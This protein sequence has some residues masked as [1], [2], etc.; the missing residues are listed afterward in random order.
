[1]RYAVKVTGA[2][3]EEF[4]NIS[5]I[6]SEFTVTKLTPPETKSPPFEIPQSPNLSDYKDKIIE[7][8]KQCLYS[9]KFCFSNISRCIE[10]ISKTKDSVL[11]RKLVVDTVKEFANSIP[12][13]MAKFSTSG[14]IYSFWS[15]CMERIHR[16]RVYC[17]SATSSKNEMN[18]RDTFLHH[19]KDAY[20]TNNTDMFK[21]VVNVIVGEYINT[22]LSDEFVENLK[23][24]FNFMK[25][26][27]LFED[28]FIHNFIESICK[29]I[30]ERVESNKLMDLSVYLKDLSKKIYNLEETKARSLLQPDSEDSKVLREVKIAIK[31]CLIELR[32]SQNTRDDLKSLA[33]QND[34]DAIN[35][36]A[37][38]CSETS[39]FNN[40][41]SELTNVFRDLVADSFNDS[42]PISIIISYYKLLCGLSFVDPGFSSTLCKKLL[43]GFEKGFNR[44]IVRDTDKDI[45]KD[46]TAEYLADS[47]DRAFRDTSG[48]VSVSLY[49]S[50]FRLLRYKDYFGIYYNKYLF[51]RAIELDRLNL[52]HDKEFVDELRKICGENYTKSMAQIIDDVEFSDMIQKEICDELSL[53]ENNF[54]PVLLHLELNPNTPFIPIKFPDNIMKIQDYMKGYVLKN[55]RRQIAWSSTLSFV[56]LTAKNIVGIS[57]VYCNSIH[58]SILL[59]LSNG[60]MGKDELINAILDTEKMESSS[61]EQFEHESLEVCKE[62]I[63]SAIE[64]LQK[65][66]TGRII[67]NR[68]KLIL[69]GDAS[70]QNGVLNVLNL[71]VKQISSSNRKEVEFDTVTKEAAKAAIVKVLKERKT[72][73]KDSLRE[74]LSESFHFTDKLFE[75]SVAYLDKNYYIKVDPSGRIHYKPD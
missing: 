12:D 50:L 34:S 23:E 16:L 59:E 33:I 67:L 13:K 8:M 73:D 54:K 2:A 22:D 29:N 28:H 47:I 60:P 31:E 17:E 37:E 49:I 42:D 63:A 35:C 51:R 26:I 32:L 68:D 21:T 57:T 70:S 6:R 19:V 18:I 62:A 41:I 5:K 30:K 53:V 27:G 20:I 43:S 65:K 69:N 56:T 25:A 71:R 46:E 66:Q 10:C 11:L 58:A 36:W 7:T 3:F 14:E 40:F 38:L 15:N 75:D 1:M 64:T 61:G 48:D 52:Q 44:E 39:F 9:D 4:D 55:R 24:P 72:M 45:D 74:Y